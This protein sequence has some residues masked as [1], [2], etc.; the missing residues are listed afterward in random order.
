MSNEPEKLS[1]CAD[2]QGTKPKYTL[3]DELGKTNF[4]ILLKRGTWAPDEI[5]GA[6][7]RILNGGI[8]IQQYVYEE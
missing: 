6:C 4:P 7:E 1:V 3:L 8:K 5:L 2:I